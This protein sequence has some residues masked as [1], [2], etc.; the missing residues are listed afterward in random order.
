MIIKSFFATHVF[1]YMNFE[2]NFNKD[3]NFLVG[4]N[5]SGKTTALKLINALIMPNFKELL[6]TQFSECYLLLYI[7]GKEV[8]I[9][10][11]KREDTLF[12]GVNSIEDVLEIPY[13][14][15]IVLEVKNRKDS[16]L[17]LVINLNLIVNLSLSLA[18]LVN[19]FKY[20]KLKL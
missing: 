6:K 2:I 16:S 5:G 20:N 14:P 11:Y 8:C 1:G 7:H 12:F 19:T 15:D 4:K 3:K 9:Y 10:S 17:L 13:R 18:Y